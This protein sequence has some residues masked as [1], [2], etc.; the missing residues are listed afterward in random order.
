MGVDYTKEGK[1]AVFIINRP[2]VMNALDLA[3]LSDFHEAL[4][5]FREKIP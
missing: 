5:D 1:V 3:S 4:I 2:H